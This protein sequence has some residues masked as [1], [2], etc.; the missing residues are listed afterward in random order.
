MVWE[1]RVH[2][3]STEKLGSR[4]ILCSRWGVADLNGQLHLFYRRMCLS[5]LDQDFL[6]QLI[7]QLLYE[8]LPGLNTGRLRYSLLTSAQRGQLKCCNV[9]S[10]F[11]LFP[12]QHSSF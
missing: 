5:L 9:L 11:S 4:T 8:N 1:T 10:R 3:E 6:E 2:R 12:H 7:L